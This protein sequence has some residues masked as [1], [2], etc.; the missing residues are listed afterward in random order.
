MRRLGLLFFS[1][2]SCTSAEPSASQGTV[3]DRAEDD[4]AP[5]S[6]TPLA[7]VPTSEEPWV[8]AEP[9][10]AAQTCI[11]GCPPGY[12]FDESVKSYLAPQATFSV[13]HA[14]GARTRLRHVAR[15]G[16]LVWERGFDRDRQLPAQSPSRTLCCGSRV[17]V[18]VA[19]V[20]E[21]RY[22]LIQFGSRDGTR[23]PGQLDRTIAGGPMPHELQL[24]C[25]ENEGV[26]VFGRFGSAEDSTLYVDEVTT[27]LQLR[28]SRQLP[29]AV[30]MTASVE[31]PR[32]RP[33]RPST[34]LQYRF[35]RRRSRGSSY[36]PDGRY[37]RPRHLVVKAIHEGR[38]RWSADLGKVTSY[39]Q[40]VLEV[41]P[42][43]IV[44]VNEML[45]AF[46]TLD[47]RLAWQRRGWGSLGERARQPGEFSF[48]GSTRWSPPRHDVWVQDGKLVLTST[49]R[50]RWVNVI[51]PVTGRAWVRRIWN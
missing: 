43:T 25:L 2:V 4:D 1:L 26:R 6:T 50:F 13:E 32:G 12:T 34:T 11:G 39:T 29:A 3:V 40:Q 37:H 31:S 22:Q 28:A 30:A 38:E 42:L 49:G 35:V 18:A 20:H 48:Y 33:D 36:A 7:V 16:V 51:D 46:R 23:N 21:A 44:Q 10:A 27:E 45:T 14:T 9:L 8:W 24:G 19:A 41:G 47:G 5:E 15:D 17:Y